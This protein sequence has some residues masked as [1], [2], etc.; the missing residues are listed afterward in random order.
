M[1]GH[2]FDYATIRVVPRV[3]FEE[4]INAGVVVHCSTRRYLGCRVALDAAR[5]LALDPNA[6]VE[7][8]RRHLHAFVRVCQGDLGAGPI[9]R[10]PVAERFHWLTGPRNTIIQTSAVHSGLTEDPE[11]ILPKLLLRLVPVTP[12]RGSD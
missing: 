8:I 12:P 3:E 1:P 6:D 7:T 2:V 4:F 10:L 5:L 9:A 11:S